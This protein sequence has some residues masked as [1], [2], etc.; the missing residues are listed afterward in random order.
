[1]VGDVLRPDLQLP[2][3][4]RTVLHAVSYDPQAGHTRHELYAGGLANVLAHL[5]DTVQRFV[6]ISSTSV[7][8]PAEGGWVDEDTPCKPQQEGG[9]ACLAAEQVL[10]ESPWAACAVVLR[11]AGLYGP[12]R[13]PRASD[14]RAGRPIPADPETW[15]NLIH[16][17]DAAQVVL[18][19]AEHP[20]PSPRYVVSDGQPVRRGVFYAELARLLGAPPPVFSVPSSDAPARSEGDKRICPQRMLQELAP[21]LRYPSFREG[22]A[23]LAAGL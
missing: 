20:S 18:L 12:G 10:A 8:G 14:V 4:I 7:Y 11:L 22:L 17:E 3:G 6:Q 23:A 15:L 9:R 21:R 16:V 13:L 5:P 19:A 1:V 2:H